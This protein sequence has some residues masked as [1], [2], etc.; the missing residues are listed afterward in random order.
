MRS[1]ATTIIATL[2][3]ALVCG[4]GKGTRAS[5]EPINIPA[6]N[7][8]D[9]GPSLVEGEPTIDSPCPSSCA[10]GACDGDTCRRCLLV[11]DAREDPDGRIIANYAGLAFT[12]TQ[13]EPAAAMTVVASGEVSTG[14]RCPIWS[15]NLTVETR[16]GGAI[17]TLPIDARNEVVYPV[18]VEGAAT[19]SATGTIDVTIKVGEL[20]S[21]TGDVCGDLVLVPGF[22]VSIA[23]R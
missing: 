10:T 9:A 6:I 5:R 3:V 13:M 11:I 17:A 15:G 21:S 12:C 18:H 4:C 1:L 2:L 16:R 14:R 22:T 7:L 23:E 19:T 8:A 20:S